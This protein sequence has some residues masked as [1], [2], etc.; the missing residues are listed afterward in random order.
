MANSLL[1]RYS[2][3]PVL[4]VLAAE[5]YADASSGVLAVARGSDKNAGM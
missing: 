5:L 3:G 2:S 1:S 4:A